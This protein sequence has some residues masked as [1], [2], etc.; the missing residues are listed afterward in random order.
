MF[1]I[2]L[3]IVFLHGNFTISSDGLQSI[4][5]CLVPINTWYVHKPQMLCQ[6]VSDLSVL[7]KGLPLF[8]CTSKVYC[9]NSLNM[10]ISWVMNRHLHVKG[11]KYTYYLNSSH[12]KQLIV[13]ET[14]IFFRI[15]I[16]TCLCKYS[17]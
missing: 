6:R 10:M 8:S 3:D 13:N 7:S 5:L 17:H 16:Y 2:L 4:G 9:E 11:S 12:N 15:I 1:Y 14:K